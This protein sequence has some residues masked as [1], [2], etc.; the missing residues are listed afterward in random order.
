MKSRTKMLALGTAAVVAA[1]LGWNALADMPANGSSPMPMQ[2]E[3]HGAALYDVGPMMMMGRAFVDP[4]ASLASLKRDLG[5]TMVQGVAW[6]NYTK[7]VGEAAVAIKS[8]YWPTGK[9]GMHGNLSDGAAMTQLCNQHLQAYEKIHTAAD[10]L[11]A[12]FDQTQKQKAAEILL[13]QPF[14]NAGMPGG[15]GMMMGMMGGGM[16]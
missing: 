12:T 15:M 10:T 13:G 11:A 1:G 8:M 4:T 3:G 6:D 9:G 16:M 7:A 5:I 2:Y 14:T